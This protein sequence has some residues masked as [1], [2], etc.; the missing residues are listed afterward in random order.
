MFPVNLP[1]PTTCSGTVGVV[2]PMPTLPETMRPFEG[3]GAEAAY[4]PIATPP[5]T[6]NLDNCL[7]VPIPALPRLL[8]LN[9]VVAG[10]YPALP[11]PIWKSSSLILN[12]GAHDGTAEF[13]SDHAEPL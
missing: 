12:C 11:R 10:G 2:I 8:I 7:E 9:K 3:A 5:T 6:S 4:E 1:S 13:T